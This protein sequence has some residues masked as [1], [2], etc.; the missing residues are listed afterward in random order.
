[1]EKKQVD[2]EGAQKNTCGHV[3]ALDYMKYVAKLS[4]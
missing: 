4:I 2:A 3:T 1:M